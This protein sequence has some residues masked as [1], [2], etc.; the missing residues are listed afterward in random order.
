[1]GTV[2]A[3]SSGLLSWMLL[4]LYYYSTFENNDKSL[5]SKYDFEQNVIYRYC[6]CKFSKK[7]NDF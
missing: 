5:F 3:S 1:M 4:E 6:H 7:K 2:D